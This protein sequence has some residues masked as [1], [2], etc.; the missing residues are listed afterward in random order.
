[1][2]HFFKSTLLV[3]FLC[4]ST[5]SFAQTLGTT[6]YFSYVPNSAFNVTVEVIWTTET[7]DVYQGVPINQSPI[8]VGHAVFVPFPASVDV[9]ASVETTQVN[10]SF[11]NSSFGTGKIYDGFL[12]V[13][14]FNGT[15]F[16][17]IYWWKIITIGPAVRGGTPT[18]TITQTTTQP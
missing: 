4:L 9:A 8:N 6:V 18:Y 13:V 11:N 14:D 12:A 7:G 16:P 5:S 3:I 1:M 2:K 15:D 17:P 10:V